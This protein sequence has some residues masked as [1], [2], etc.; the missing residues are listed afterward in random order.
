MQLFEI[1]KKMIVIDGHHV[2]MVIFLK[3]GDVI[4]TTE[5]AFSNKASKYVLMRQL[6]TDAAKI[7]AD[8]VIMISEAC[9]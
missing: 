4:Y 1:A 9:P 6:G 8:G 2:P 5:L 3:D 7:S